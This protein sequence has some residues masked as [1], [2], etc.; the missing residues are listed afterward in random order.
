MSAP[1]RF[2]APREPRWVPY[3]PE[4]PIEAAKPFAPIGVKGAP[5]YLALG[6]WWSRPI[7]NMSHCLRGFASNDRRAQG[8][9]QVIARTSSGTKKKNR[10][11]VVAEQG[12]L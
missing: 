10:S 2:N 3:L 11:A 6:E 1:E 9:E 12:R 8:G 7:G 5:E 4:T